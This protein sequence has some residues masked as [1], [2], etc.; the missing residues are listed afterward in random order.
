MGIFALLSLLSFVV[1]FI[2]GNFVFYQDRKNPLNRIAMVLCLSLAGW[3]FVEFELRL[4]YNF[5]TS[6][7][8]WIAS[9][10]VFRVMTV[11]FVLHYTLLF[12]EAKLLKNKFAYILIYTPALIFVFYHVV[13][14]PSG[15]YV[16]IFV[17]LIRIWAYGTLFLSIM[18]VFIYQLRVNNRRK[19]QQA[20]YT[21]IGFSIVVVTN[22]ITESLLPLFQ[23]R[24]P[25]LTTTA[26]TFT[27]ALVAYA[28]RRYRLFILTPVTAAEN[29]ISIMSDSLF[30][31]DARGRITSVNR[32][33]S[34]LLG[35][36]ANELIGKP[37]QII[38]SE[39]K[40][41]T[42]SPKKMFEK[43]A[44]MKTNAI[45][46]VETVF[47]AKDGKRIPISLSISVMRNEDDEPQGIIYIGRDI[48]ERKR[49]EELIKHMAT[50]D[51]LTGLPN[52]VMF[53]DRFALVMAQ[54]RRNQQKIA[55]M[56]L[57]L[58]Q[59][60][61]INDTLGHEA[62]DRLLK[63]V[64]DHLSQLLRKSDTIAR[65]GGDEFVILL[66][67]ITRMEDVD[68]VAK[69]IL[70]MFQKSFMLERHKFNITVSIGIAIYPDDAEDADT[71]LKKADIAMYKAK[72]HGRNNYQYY[73]R[74]MKA[75]F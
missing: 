24:I 26:F 67:G 10:H 36:K 59:F 37:M 68:K 28:I 27:T 71:L 62:G 73:I 47:K 46:E 12:T 48:T 29:I 65:M 53:N 51:S 7:Y 19:R 49:E 31:V 57:D 2:L 33:A 17:P 1:I 70:N 69:K 45:S 4:A 13:I 50:H 14:E 66:P 25:N 32:G 75:E 39:E 18:L 43:I 40:N 11:A 6:Y 30:L 38:F 34:K 20:K 72:R 23:I 21:S 5:E 61:D 58:D 15:K 16:S 22:L 41:E 54:A 52:R 63:K 42:F 35:Y 55:L 56:F 9:Y 44:N 60:K 64:A 3:S 8:P 74:D